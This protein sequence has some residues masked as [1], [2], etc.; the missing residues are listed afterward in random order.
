[1]AVVCSCQ[2]TA[3]H[4]TS[5]TV[6]ADRTDPK[7]PAPTAGDIFPLLGLEA[8]PNGRAVLTFRNVGDVDYG[9]AY[10]LEL[11]G[12]TILDNTLQR[13]SDIGHF[14]E[15]LDSLVTKGNAKGYAF[16]RSSILLPLVGQLEK[17]GGTD[18]QTKVLLLY[19]DLAENSD[20]FD[21]YGDRRLLLEYPGEVAG[22]LRARLDIPDLEGVTLYIVNYPRDQDD[23]RMFRAW[24]AVYQAL[25]K[26]SGLA[27]RIGIDKSMGRIR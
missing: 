15:A 19:S 26:E 27:I 11:P 5:L 21:S 12:A 6:L 13:R 24:C 9:P 25:F 17:L 7:I 4:S 1:M 23:N 8:H 18:A 14:R 16:E 10:V 20:V 22:E 2:L 3:P